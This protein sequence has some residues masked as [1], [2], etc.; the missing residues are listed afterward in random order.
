[1]AADSEAVVYRVND[2]HLGRAIRACV[3]GGQRV[4][5]LGSPVVC[6]SGVCF[7]VR[8]L[9]LVGTLVAYESF[10]SNLTGGEWFVVVRNLR[11]GRI[12]RHIPTGT[13]LKPMSETGVGPVTDLVVKADGSVVWIA[14]DIERRIVT[15]VPYS[16]TPYFDVY[17]SD[18]AGTRLLA[19]GADI[20]SS[21]LALAGGTVYWSEAGR[22]SSALVH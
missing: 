4:V 5:G 12:I 3:Y 1:M 18:A 9:Q 16:E 20:Q 14:D 11:S 2:P 21:S 7:G 19:A 10:L 13:S 8:D 15:N 6:G 22:A 17:A